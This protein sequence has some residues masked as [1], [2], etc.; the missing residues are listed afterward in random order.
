MK[1]F[2]T[3]ILFLTL[4]ILGLTGCAGPGFSDKGSYESARPIPPMPVVTNPNKGSIYQVGSSL[5]LFEDFRARQVGD[6]L[7]VILSEATQAAKSSDTSID[8]TNSST[9]TNPV[10]GGAARDL[11]GDTLQFE[12]SSERS[13]EGESGANQSNSLSGELTVTVA[14]VYANGNLYVQGEKWIKIN[15]GNEYIRLRGIVRPADIT[16]ENTV[17]STRVADAWISYGG[18]GALAEANSGGWLARF[19]SSPLFPF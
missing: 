9:I 2:K 7:T 18:N 4:S 15:Q 19:F 10:F 1:N 6:T 14:E 3:M 11:N 13:F 5:G 17:V 16:P 8:K 12:L